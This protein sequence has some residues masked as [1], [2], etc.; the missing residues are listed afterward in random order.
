MVSILLYFRI[1]LVPATV[2]GDCSVEPLST[3]RSRTRIDSMSSGI[4]LL[5]QTTI[6]LTYP[7]VHYHNER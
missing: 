2:T 1:V 6:K 4:Q 5:P 7:Y 3:Y